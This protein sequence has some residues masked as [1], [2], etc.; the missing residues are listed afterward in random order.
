MSHI[1]LQ[2]PLDKNLMHEL[3]VGQWVYLS[4]SMVTARDAALRKINDLI[5]ENKKPSVDFAGQLI[6][7]VG[8]T[9]PAE[10]EAIGSAG[11]TTSN[12]MESYMTALLEAGAVGFMGKGPLSSGAVSEVQRQG[13]LYLAAV[14]GAG[15]FYGSK[16]KG[17]ALLAFEELGPEAIYSLH[18]EA[19]PAV[20]AID[21][22]GG[23]LFEEGPKAYV[24]KEEA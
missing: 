19:F 22:H 10:G 2:L 14:G 7:F 5:S 23:N 6:Y 9:P 13:A 11:P 1:N 21:L 20:V 12:R 16:I 15:A 17:A 18:V 8:P 3:K 4:G 24:K